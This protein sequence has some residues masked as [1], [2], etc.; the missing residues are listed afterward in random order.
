M[1]T[2]VVSRTLHTY[3]NT[4]RILCE[5][6]QIE[7]EGRD[8]RCERFLRC[9]IGSFTCVVRGVVR[10][11]VRAPFGSGCAGRGQT[12]RWSYARRRHA[13]IAP[14]LGLSNSIS[15]APGFAGGR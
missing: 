9:Q 8:H 15:R 3:H 11:E 1:I 12:R 4:L 14:Y 2:P 7:F 5:A 6:F 13:D 10:T